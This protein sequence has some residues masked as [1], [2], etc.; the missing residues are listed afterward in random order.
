[1]KRYFIK[2]EK[3]MANKGEFLLEILPKAMKFIDEECQ[4]AMNKETGGILIGYYT[5]NQ[6]TAIVTEA[7]SPPLDS[8]S[9]FTWF[10]RGEEGL[11]K[12]L[13]QRWHNM[14]KRTYYIGEWHYHPVI[15]I[16]PSNEDFK[17]MIKISGSRRYQ[18]K[19]PIMMIFGKNNNGNRKIRAFVFPN[20]KQPYEFKPIRIN[21][22]SGLS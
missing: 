18:C 4:N 7:S 9:G 6:S 17:Q 22:L 5:N 14:N 20:S 10:H 11:K 8:L 3:W 1:M 16:S 2:Q 21:L 12:I 15:Q 19:D 13:F